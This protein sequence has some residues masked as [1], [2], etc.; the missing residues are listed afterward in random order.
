M[1]QQLID[2]KYKSDKKLCKIIKNNKLIPFAIF[3]FRN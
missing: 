2:G 3:D 1:P